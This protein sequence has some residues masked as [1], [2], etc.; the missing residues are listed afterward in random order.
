MLSCAP[1]RTR[2]YGLLLRRHSRKVA[3]R[4]RVWPDVPFCGSE[5]GWAWPGVAAWL[6]SLAPSLAPRDLVSNANVRMA[7]GPDAAAARIHAATCHRM[8]E[9]LPRPPM[10][11]AAQLRGTCH[12]EPAMCG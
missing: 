12:A 10:A 8:S 5:N 6:W 7:R 1:S 9:M 11:R 2:T 4:R 3:C